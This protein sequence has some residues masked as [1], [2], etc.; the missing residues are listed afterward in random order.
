MKNKNLDDPQD[1]DGT[2]NAM[3]STTLSPT[4]PELVLEEAREPILPLW[5][6]STDALADASSSSNVTPSNEEPLPAIDIACWGPTTEGLCSYWVNKGVKA[7]ILCQN[8][9]IFF[10]AGF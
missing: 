10:T 5:S 3:S 9:D 2:P 7:S 1:H 4:S 8:K 6:T